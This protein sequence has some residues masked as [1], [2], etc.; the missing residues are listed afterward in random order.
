MD[1]ATAIRLIN[2]D[3]QFVVENND[4]NKITWIKTTPISVADIQ[5]KDAAS[6]AAIKAEQDSWDSEVISATNK[7]KALGLTEAE[8]K[9]FIVPTT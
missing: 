4:V 6:D 9:H 7:L 8:I 1:V 3:A 5:A 2:P